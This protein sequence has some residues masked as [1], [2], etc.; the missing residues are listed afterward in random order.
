MKFLLIL[1]PALFIAGVGLVALGGLL[2]VTGSPGVCVDRE[3]VPEPSPPIAA[4]LDERWDSFSRD[5][6]VQEATIEITEAEATARGRQYVDAESVP[7]DDLR[8]YFCGE[9][10]G[11]IA[12]RVGVLGI[13]A[14]FVAT[15][16]LDISGR[17]PT[18]TLDSV[19][20]GSLPGF[21]SDAVLDLL[22]NE[23]ARSLELD[24]N[25][26]GSE[27]RDGFIVISG[28]P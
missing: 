9:D 24:E 15:G 13:D 25:L 23:D 22:L 4:Q 5:A 7:I 26:T 8:V 14:D 10:K 27:I 20:V 18:V 6:M 2:I 12:G 19:D 17:N 21:V 28:A 3:I 1:F 11:Q 16:S